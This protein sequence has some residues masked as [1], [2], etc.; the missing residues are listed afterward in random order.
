MS[1][2]HECWECPVCGEVTS[3]RHYLQRDGVMVH[4]PDAAFREAV[5]LDA[6]EPLPEASNGASA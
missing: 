3:V 5:G 2:R 6:P 4:D 1:A